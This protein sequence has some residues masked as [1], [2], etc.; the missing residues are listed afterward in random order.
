MGHWLIRIYGN[1]LLTIC[2]FYVGTEEAAKQFA[3]DLRDKHKAQ[4]SMVTN[5]EEIKT[6]SATDATKGTFEQKY[7]EV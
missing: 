2:A 6:Y 1:V 5:V 7:Q 4:I 3:A